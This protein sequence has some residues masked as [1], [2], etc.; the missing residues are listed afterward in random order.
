MNAKRVLMKKTAKKL[1]AAV[2]A[3]MMIVSAQSSMLAVS[4]GAEKGAS[5]KNAE[6]HLNDVS[7]DDVQKS[8][9]IIIG[10]TEKLK[11]IMS[12]DEQ[13][14]IASIFSSFTSVLGN[15]YS[16]ISVIN[17]SVA[18]MQLIGLMKNSTAVG[19][20]NI[21]R[22]LVN[23]DEKLTQMDVKL[24]KIRQQMTE[25]QA[26]A[27]FEARAIKAN[28]MLQTWRNFKHNYMETQMD[29]QMNDFE[30]M[31]L[32]SMRAWIENKSEGAR[33][34][35]EDGLSTSKIVIHYSAVQK[36]G[37]LGPLDFEYVL[38]QPPVNDIKP[39]DDKPANPVP[40]TMYKNDDEFNHRFDKYMILGDWFLPQKGD[41][42]WNVN[43]FRTTLVKFILA[44]LKSV[45]DSAAAGDSAAVKESG[46]VV[47]NMDLASLTDEELSV[48]AEDAVNTLVYRVSYVA[49]NVS[50]DFARD[51]YKQ[52]GE[53]VG[54]VR[55][56]VDAMLKAM[57]LTHAFEYEISK[58]I[59][60][61]CNE[62][63]LRTGVYS[64]FA[65]NVA[66]MSE[67]ITDEQK[68]SVADL[69]CGSIDD[70]T[71]LLNNAI[72]G[73]GRYCYVTGTKLC[74]GE[75]TFS[76]AATMD[77]YI[78]GA[79]SGY[80]S[81][82]AQP[83]SK[84]FKYNDSKDGT[85]PSPV[86]DSNALVISYLIKT[87]GSVLDH[88]YMTEHLNGKGITKRGALLTTINPEE[89]LTTQ[90]NLKLK[91]HK[92]IGGYFAKDPEI[93]PNKLPKSAEQEYLVHR[94]MITGT[95]FDG[96]TLAMN[97]TAPLIGLAA[98]GENH[99]YW[100][101]DEMALMGGPCDDSAYKEDFKTEKTDS[102]LFRDEWRASYSNS[103]TYNCLLSV[104][105]N[106][107]K[108]IPGP[109][110]LEE[111]R[112]MRFTDKIPQNFTATAKTVKAKAKALK[113]KAKTVKAVTVKNASGTLKFKKLS[114]NKKSG[115][116]AVNSK[117]GKIKLKKGLPKGT[118]KVK[119]KVTAGATKVYESADQ[120]VTVKVKVK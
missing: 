74:Y 9:D 22:Q 25:M 103:M 18:F 107:L 61:L 15:A 69:M 80:E 49:M 36:K 73:E 16:V 10:S 55:E 59:E 106:P 105:Y 98:Y 76:G 48:L 56:G 112:E 119:I 108:M 8:I 34:T 11:D 84:S 114:V 53:Y 58:D 44:K 92:I 38:R 70:L 57:Y 26:K 50:A 41:I 97:Q 81:Y 3:L 40:Y 43:T 99:W 111:L 64:M 89:T 2:M 32:N 88:D 4:Y 62:M 6:M 77:Y 19:V 100:E 51:V 66:G 87:S 65:S 83:F 1:V 68:L 46:I 90:T 47:Y 7:K 72:T 37:G 86:G 20:A 67:F 93:Y 33:T 28:Q 60:D 24:D 85:N 13:S 39:D 94:K 91:T 78:Q 30:T 96:N 117:T 27:D 110:P 113:K 82:S 75:V 95:K 63:I 14:T 21:S 54:A 102:G 42:Q 35:E 5:E 116:F 109:Y 101:T 71:S 79:V 45:R 23:I 52:Y 115:K 12:T 118:Y 104:P 17:G 29:K 31:M 120:V